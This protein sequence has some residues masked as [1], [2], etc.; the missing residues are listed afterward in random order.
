MSKDKKNNDEREHQIRLIHV[1]AT[2]LPWIA[3]IA[4]FLATLATIIQ[5]LVYS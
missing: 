3:V 2:R 1:L 4:V 5:I